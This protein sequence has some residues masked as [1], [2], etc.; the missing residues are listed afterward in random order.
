[1]DERDEATRWINLALKLLVNQDLVGIKTF[2]I[3]AKEADPMMGYAEEIL[4]VVDTLMEIGDVVE[5]A[6]EWVA[7][8]GG[9]V[10]VGD[11]GEDDIF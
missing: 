9:G 10:W 7:V 1:M 2:A 3:R 5:S 11:G 4:A 6:E 8:C